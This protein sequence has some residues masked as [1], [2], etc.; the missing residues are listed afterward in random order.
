MKIILPK[1]VKL[2]ID[3]LIAH[4]YDAYAVGGCIR[5]S[6]LGRIPNDWDITTSAKPAEV[7]TIFERTVDTGIKHGTVTVLINHEPYEVTTYRIDGD[8]LDSRH[9]ESVTFTSD[10]SEDLR[11]RDFTINAMAYNDQKGL[12]DIFDGQ[13]DIER[14]IIRAVGNP[15]ERFNEDALRIMRAVRFAGQLGY[16]IE[17]NTFLAGAAAV[18][19]LEN[20]SAERIQIELVKLMKSDYPQLL[21]V[22]YKMG[23]TKV[24]LP[25]YDVMMKTAQNTPH[26]CYSVGEHTLKTICNIQ[27]N[28][29]EI[30]VVG[31]KIPYDEEVFKYLRLAMLFHDMGKPDCKSTDENGRDHFYGHPAVS[32]KICANIMRRLKFDNKTLNI[33]KSLV[34]YHDARVDAK[35]EI[36]RKWINKMGLNIFEL[37]FLVQYA[38]I[39]AQSDYKR[40]EKLKR[41]SDEYLLYLDVMKNN[42][43]LFIK[44]LKINGR[45]I[46]ENGIAQGEKLGRILDQ[47][48]KEVLINPK[49]N[50]KEQLLELAK[51]RAR[52]II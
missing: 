49:L 29:N 16:Q 36:V 28:G 45:D 24:I 37:E 48:M 4:G 13:G 39:Y 25:E 38:D 46:L 11:R 32:A 22:A 15:E 5:D 33:V 6:L 21:D 7:K 42:D 44:D 8:Y 34:E 43:P 30:E 2:I 52:E 50:T 18:K 1:N 47:L 35:P 40:E 31:Y 41:V 51:K 20:I 3:S 23:I 26:H 12:V 19:R 10:L 17:E 9:P 27:K 14:K